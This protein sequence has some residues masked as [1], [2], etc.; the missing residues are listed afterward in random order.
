VSVEIG[1]FDR[2]VSFEQLTPSES[3]IAAGRGMP[4]PGRVP[5]DFYRR[6]KSVGRN[7]RVSIGK[8]DRAN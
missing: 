5:I 2:H 3:G 6:K 1:G 8:N 4:W 7:G